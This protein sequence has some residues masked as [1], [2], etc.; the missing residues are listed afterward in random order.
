[1][2]V[3]GDNGVDHVKRAEIYGHRSVNQP[4]RS[5]LPRLFPSNGHP[6]DDLKEKSPFR[7][8]L[9]VLILLFAFCLVVEF[10]CCLPNASFTP[11]INSGE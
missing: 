1:M 5:F 8:E 6:E 2:E 9:S 3:S 10:M 4:A 11:K 7:I